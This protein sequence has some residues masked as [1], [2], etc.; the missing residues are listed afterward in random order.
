[1]EWFK[2]TSLLFKIVF[3]SAAFILKFIVDVWRDRETRNYRNRSEDDKK[4]YIKVILINAVSFLM[5]ILILL[6]FI[7]MVL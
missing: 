2:E 6:P 1:M 4:Y 5:T 7:L 3:M